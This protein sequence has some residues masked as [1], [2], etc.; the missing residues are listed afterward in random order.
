M[1]LHVA[2]KY[3][4]SFEKAIKRAME[5]GGIPSWIELTP[6][7]ALEFLG[8]LQGLRNE[9]LTQ[10][11][12]SALHISHTDEYFGIVYITMTSPQTFGLEEK[13]EYVRQWYKGNISIS[14]DGVELRVVQPTK[15]VFKNP[16]RYKEGDVYHHEQD[17]G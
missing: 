1:I 9:G 7:E 15:H 10:H 5:L 17:R 12:S 14:Y 8:E 2:N 16:G 11:N 4:M 3:M 13:K 6:K